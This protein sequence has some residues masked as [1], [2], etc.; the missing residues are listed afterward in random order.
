MVE[1]GRAAL[2]AGVDAVLFTSASTVENF[3]RNWGTPPVGAVVCCIGP[4]TAEAAQ[5]AGIAS[6]AESPES[7]IEALVNTLIEAVRR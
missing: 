3:V 2:R 5:R 4:K 1:A 6:A 7:S